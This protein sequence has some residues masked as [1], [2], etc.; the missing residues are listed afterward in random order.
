MERI[1]SR[2]NVEA[3]LRRVRRNK[4]SAGIDGM[5]V[6][7][8]PAY[9]AAEW[10]RIERELLAGRYQPQPVRRHVIPKRGGGERML[11]IPTALDRLIQQ[12]ILQVLQPR[13]DPRFSEHSY[14]FRP[15][16]SAHDAIR[17][18][19]DYIQSGRAWVVDVDLEAF[20]DRVNHDVLMAR[21]ARHVADTRLLV[22][23][24]AYLNAG[25]MAHGVV[26]ERYEGTPQGGPLSPL[27]ANILLDDV[28]RELEARG[29]AFVRY[30][31]DCNVYVRSRRA[32]ERVM[33]LLRRLYGALHLTVNEAKSAV[34]RPL[35]R[36]FLGYSVWIGPKRAVKLRVA[37]K[38]LSALKLRVRAL[39][40]RNRG[41]S[42]RTIVGELRRFLMGWRTYFQLAETPR[43]LATI[44]EW[45][46]HRLRAIHLKHWKTASAI[47]RELRARGLSATAARVVASN[48]RRW[49]KNSG[50]AI[51]IALPVRYF[52]QLGLPRLS[53]TP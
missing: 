19:R 1:V 48:R 6:D 40:R 20:F 52:D 25:M 3:A 32:G 28:D 18:A 24:R 26:V 35:E 33:A 17:V 27:L 16:R 36:T 30:A 43:V 51:T 14:G 8:L 10:P 47:E 38:A 42:I 34:A 12:C 9:V 7:E 50:Y 29:H 49:W 37:P 11:G 41:D 31:D 53:T 23:I 45:I 5:T 2:R 22:L 4:G 46:R 13:I 39:T 21:V 44:D 15:G